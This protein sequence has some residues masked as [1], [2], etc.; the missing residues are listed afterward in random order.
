MSSVAVPRAVVYTILTVF[1]FGL[2]ISLLTEGGQ[3]PEEDNSTN[4]FLWV[5]CLL[6]SIAVVSIAMVL[7]PVGLLQNVAV[8]ALLA[9]IM[10]HVIVGVTVACLQGT[11][12]GA[13]W[14][15][16]ATGLGV[17]AM[18]VGGVSLLLMINEWVAVAGKQNVD[19]A[20]L[21]TKSKKQKIK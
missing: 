17:V 16:W 11:D 13:D 8:G 4:W 7:K 21:F 12:Q 6:L 3:T 5:C 19:I 10:G 14:D 1:L 9:I 2:G 20:G 18:V 15:D